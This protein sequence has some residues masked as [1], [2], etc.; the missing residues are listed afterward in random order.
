MECFLLLCL[1]LFLFW[2][3]VSVVR[4]LWNVGGVVGLDLY[5]VPT[6]GSLPSQ[7]SYHLLEGRLWRKSLSITKLMGLPD[8]P[9]V[10]ELCACVYV[11]E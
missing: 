8:A 5:G 3:A 9:Y 4:G 10:M 1:V 7:L 11:R 2:N 6:G